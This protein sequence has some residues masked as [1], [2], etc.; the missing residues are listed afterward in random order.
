MLR[1]IQIR[2][3]PTKNQE[4]LLWKHIHTCRFVWNYFLSVQNERYQN[5]EKFIGKY[6]MCNKLTEL[7]HDGQHNWL[8]EVSNTSLQIICSD[9][10]YAFKQFFDKNSRYPKFKQ[11][12]R[13]AYR[14]PTRSNSFYFYNEKTVNIEKV[15]KVKYKTDLE[16]E[17]GKNKNKFANVRICYNLGKWYVRFAVER[18]SQAHVLNDYSIGIDLGVKELAV[19]ECD[20]TK[21]IFH[22]INK[23][24]KMKNIERRIKHSQQKLSRKYRLNKDGNR[25]VKT[26][27]MIREEEKLGKL[28]RKQTNIKHNYYHHITHS[29]VN[30]LPKRVVMENLDIVGLGKNKSMSKKVRDQSFSVFIHQMRYKCEDMGI[31]FIQADRFFPSSKTCS[32]CGFVK[33]DL[34]LDNRI[35]NCP[36]CGISIDRDYNAAINLSRYKA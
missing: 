32:N 12:K 24:T 34:K 26:K 2:L 23:T 15:G 16:F 18:D 36:N 13:K 1:S 7:K 20:G 3:Y 10:E 9:L 21:Q 5:G 11:K 14:F 35:F 28:Y 29:L 19:V 33:S 27:N 30:K 22:N 8:Y 31:P 4:E 17:Y 25:V 6:A